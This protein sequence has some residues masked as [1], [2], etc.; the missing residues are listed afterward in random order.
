MSQYAIRR[1]LLA[2]PILWGMA[3]ILFVVVRLTPGDVVDALVSND[4]RG[5]ITAEERAQIADRVRRETGLDRPLYVQYFKWLGNIVTGSLGY[6]YWQ[7]RSVS[8]MIAERASVTVELATL[9]LA[10][11]LLWAIPLGLVSGLKRD[12]WVDHT[13]RV[14]SVAG[15][16]I[17]NFWLGIILIF[18]FLSWFKWI[19]P[20]QWA[21]LWDDPITN[22]KQIALPV[23]VTAYTSGAPIARL[24]RAETLEVL[25][26]DYVRTARAKGLSSFVVVY[27]HVLRN[28]LLPV[29]TLAGWN[30]GRLLGGLVVIEYAFNLPGLG[31]FLVQAILFRDYDAIGGTVLALA[32]A[33]VI[34]NLA[35][36]LLYGVIDP[37]VRLR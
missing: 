24:T 15:I 35:I 14:T 5:A 23:L 1:L 33:I 22:L 37:R 2:V 29:V 21:D 7:R 19:P 3:T 6:S 16:S 32:G 12:S 9:G 25:S 26:E 18:A 17:P 8:S 13:L 30:F 20:L 36:D 28:A 4:M 11:A 10:F 31:S 27:R 34:I